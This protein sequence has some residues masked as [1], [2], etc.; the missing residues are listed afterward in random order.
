MEDGDSSRPSLGFPLGLVLLL[1]MLFFM[2]GLFTAC[3][4]WDKLRSMLGASSE[5]DSSHIEEDIEH[6]PRK[7]AP[8]QVVYS[9][10]HYIHLETLLR[11]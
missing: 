3:L 5:D 9:L 6:P 1:L 4:H 8:P 11:S 2:S 10:L 7:S